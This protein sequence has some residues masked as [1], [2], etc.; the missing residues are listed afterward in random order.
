MHGAR[1]VVPDLPAASLSK[2]EVERLWQL[3]RA[4][5]RVFCLVAYCN[6]I[7]QSDGIA[8]TFTEVDP[9]STC[10]GDDTTRLHT[11]SITVFSAIFVF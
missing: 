10:T 2:W 9:S 3:G 6:V 1:S 4:L 11:K 7:V 8:S 5:H